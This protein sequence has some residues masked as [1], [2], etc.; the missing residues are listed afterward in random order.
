MQT[1][2]MSDADSWND[3]P[4]LVPDSPDDCGS[5]RHEVRRLQEELQ[6]QDSWIRELESL[7]EAVYDLLQAKFLERDMLKLEL[8]VNEGALQGMLQDVEESACTIETQ[9][10]LLDLAWLDSGRATSS[11][12]KRKRDSPLLHDHRQGMCAVG[13]DEA[14]IRKKRR[15][16]P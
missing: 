11:Q 8:E 4:Y 13:E 12:R 6:R 16:G 10:G 2:A 1:P 5:P 7:L 9:S 15:L 14:H 3:G